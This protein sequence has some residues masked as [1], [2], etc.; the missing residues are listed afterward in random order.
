MKMADNVIQLIFNEHSECSECRC[1]AKISMNDGLECIPEKN[2]KFDYA[3]VLGGMSWY[4]EN[5]E[6]PQFQRSADRLFQTLWLLK[7]NKI[8][9][10]GQTASS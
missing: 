4:N 3:I 2:N 5:I 10:N 9:K 1:Y 8:E 7:Q 6:K